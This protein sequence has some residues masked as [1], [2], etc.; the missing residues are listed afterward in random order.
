MPH[1][2][3]TEHDALGFC[4]GPA[5]DEPIRSLPDWVIANILADLF[6]DFV[7]PRVRRRPRRRPRPVAVVEPP[8]PQIPVEPTPTPVPETPPVEEPVDVESIP[9]DPVLSETFHPEFGLGFGEQ[10]PGVVV[11]PTPEEIIADIVDGIKGALMGL[12]DD[13]FGPKVGGFLGG[14]GDVIVDIGAD[15]LEA[16]I[17]AQQA[18]GIVIAGSPGGIAG[19][20]PVLTPETLNVQQA[21]VGGELIAA[22]VD[23]VTAFFGGNGN[24]NGLEA[25]GRRGI[26]LAGPSPGL[27]HSTRTGRRVPNNI[28]LAQDPES[29]RV[30]FFVFAGDPTHFKK[31]GKYPRARRHHHH[32]PLHNLPR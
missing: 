18:G 6:G 8:D 10:P 21:G 23:A 27:Y 17:N 25:I 15:L 29:E 20:T 26:R 4:I 9:V 14:V 19:D 5:C 30:D 31:I 7:I 2:F 28:A 12:L 32:P 22:G 11:V 24:G 1:Y 13:I 16:A 3:L